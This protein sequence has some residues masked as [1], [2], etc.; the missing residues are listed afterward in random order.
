[1]RRK[2]TSWAWAFSA[3]VTDRRPPDRPAWRMTCSVCGDAT[4]HHP[5]AC[6]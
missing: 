3:A 2:D 1:M 4:D 6:M 5:F